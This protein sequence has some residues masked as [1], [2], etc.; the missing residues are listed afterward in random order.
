M[1]PFIY[2]TASLLIQDIIISGHDFVVL[3]LL[4]LD[5]LYK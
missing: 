3:E 1:T 2:L 4:I 5:L